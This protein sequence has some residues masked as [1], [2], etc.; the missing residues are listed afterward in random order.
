MRSSVQATVHHA[1]A[2]Q[3]RLDA[4]KVADEQRLD[5]DLGAQ[6]LDLARIGLRLEHSAPD[7]AEFPFDMLD[8][9]MTV[10]DVG[11]VYRFWLSSTD[12]TD[13]APDTLRMALLPPSSA[14]QSRRGPGTEV[15]RSAR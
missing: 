1:V 6:A 13:Q 7:R 10:G 3:L 4:D 14:R 9:S 12:G 8:P 11:A 15:S 5:R 2:A